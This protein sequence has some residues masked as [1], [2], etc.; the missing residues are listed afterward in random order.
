MS[1]SPALNEPDQPWRAVET[2]AYVKADCSFGVA[3]LENVKANTEMQ[4]SALGCSLVA[5][6]EYVSENGHVSGKA[7]DGFSTWFC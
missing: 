5:T 7:A 6:P 3:A 2:R 1:L 4:H